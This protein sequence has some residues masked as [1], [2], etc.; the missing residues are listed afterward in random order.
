ME[1]LASWVKVLMKTYADSTESTFGPSYHVDVFI[2]MIRDKELSMRL[3]ERSPK[4][5][6]EA[7][8]FAWIQNKKNMENVCAH[9][10]NIRR[11][12]NFGNQKQNQ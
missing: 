5:L 7:V 6:D 11:S 8:Q 10:H 12:G 4:T 9:P 3:H 1:A 2:N